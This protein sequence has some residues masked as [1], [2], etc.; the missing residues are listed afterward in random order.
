MKK[1]KQY[2]VCKQ[3]LETQNKD[4]IEKLKS[5]QRTGKCWCWKGIRSTQ[6][7]RWRHKL[8]KEQRQLQKDKSN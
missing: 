4:D 6:N 7:I 2:K 5:I 8:D 3:C 1:K